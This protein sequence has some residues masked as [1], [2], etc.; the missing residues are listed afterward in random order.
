MTF[1]T[2]I[3]A[4]CDE[5]L[6]ICIAEWANNVTSGAFWTVLTI[7][8]GVMV[9]MATARYGTNRAFA[10]A[11]FISGSIS[12]MLIF[13]GLMQ[14][15]VGSIFIAVLIIGIVSLRMMER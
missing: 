15:Y 1:E 5:G 9:F 8:L 11:S 6:F 3:L 14:W 12:L 4:G 10:F 7:G 13:L 2:N